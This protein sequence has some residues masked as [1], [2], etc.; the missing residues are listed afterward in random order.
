[1]YYNARTE[2]IHGKA[3]ATVDG[4]LAVVCK[5]YGCT[6]INHWTS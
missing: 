4:Y 2:L 5:E 1:M 6:T 3:L